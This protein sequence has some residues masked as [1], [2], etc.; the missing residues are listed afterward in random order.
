MKTHLSPSFKYFF[1]LYINFFLAFLKN[2]TK[3]ESVVKTTPPV[4]QA[5]EEAELQ[6]EPEPEVVLAKEEQIP[7]AEKGVVV[8]E[9]V[10][11]HVEEIPIAEPLAEETTVAEPVVAEATVVEEA[12]VVK[13]VIEGEAEIED[14][15]ETAQEE[16]VEQ[17]SAPVEAEPVTESEVASA[18]PEDTPTEAEPEAVTPAEPESPTET[19]LRLTQAASRST[20]SAVE[21]L[22]NSSSTTKYFIAT[23]RA[24][25]LSDAAPDTRAAFWLQVTEAGKRMAVAESTLEEV[26][27]S[28]KANLAALNN[29][30]AENPD[31]VE[32][33]LNEIETINAAFSS[34]TSELA[35]VSESMASFRKIEE[36]VQESFNLKKEKFKEVFGEK[37]ESEDAVE[38][39]CNTFNDNDL[40]GLIFIAQKRLGSVA[41][42][43]KELKEVQKDEIEKALEMQRDEL[44][45]QAEIELQQTIERQEQL[46]KE[47]RVEIEEELRDGFENDL[48]KQLARQTAAH[49]THIKEEL[50]TQ[51]E[52]MK[53][54]AEML[55]QNKLE[56]NEASFLDQLLT[57][58]RESIESLEKKQEEYAKT[59]GQLVGYA[60]GVENALTDRQKIEL[61]VSNLQYLVLS[62]EE[63]QSAVMELPLKP[64]SCVQKLVKGIENQSVHAI[65]DSISTEALE[66]GVLSPKA[67]ESTLPR[68]L[69]AAK[70]QHMIG[71]EAHGLFARF[72]SSV[73][74]K[75][76]TWSKPAAFEEKDSD[77]NLDKLLSAANFYNR[78]GDLESVTRVLNQLT[79]EPRRIVADWLKE[80]RLSLEVMQALDALSAVAQS[81]IISARSFS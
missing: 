39:L 31:C 52:K 33:V 41:R 27:S 43:L 16:Q 22:N 28:A 59:L 2:L 37:L 65:I 57:E 61:S 77:L 56:E 14:L 15:S 3:V 19:I 66:S 54:E 13:S 81:Q 6:T 55:L 36:E 9:I 60:N 75:L 17:N 29:F 72:R 79:G 50:E 34:A 32:V 78:E 38:N 44:R 63:M 76:T 35:A 58:R 10:E 20:K 73:T 47:K 68:L 12:T 69:E 40:K 8:E 7:A 26:I 49:S 71:E 46:L 5:A 25:L 24:A 45:S 21:A 62:V 4:R 30:A 11:K 80:A 18:E 1:S 67:L 48:Q 53:T 64:L 74:N 23:K 51:E 70:C 42:E